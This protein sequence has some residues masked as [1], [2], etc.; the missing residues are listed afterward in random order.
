MSAP[1][2]GKQ[3]GGLTEEHGAAP[4]WRQ[5]EHAAAAA[6][7]LHVL[8]APGLCGSALWKKDVAGGGGTAP[9]AAPACPA[10]PHP[11]APLLTRFRT[12]ASWHALIKDLASRLT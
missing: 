9:R 8:V 12:V 1:R 3:D 4:S 7:R 10:H 5:Q 6:C 2:R 11:H